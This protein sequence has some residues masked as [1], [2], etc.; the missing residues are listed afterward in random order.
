MSNNKYP[1]YVIRESDFNKGQKFVGF[2]MPD[3]EVEKL[4]SIFPDGCND[5]YISEYTIPYKTGY[6]ID[7][8]PEGGTEERCEIYDRFRELKSKKDIQFLLWDWSDLLHSGYWPMF[9]HNLKLACGKGKIKH[10]QHT[11]IVMLDKVPD[12]VMKLWKKLVENYIIPMQEIMKE[13]NL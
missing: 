6:I 12:R 7:F 2:Y 13:Y 4:Q 5:D 3:V 10:N 11:V 9:D 1:H 8:M